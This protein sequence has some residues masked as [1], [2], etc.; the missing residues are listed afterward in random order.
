MISNRS[1]SFQEVQA[2]LQSQLSKTQRRQQIDNAI[3]SRSFEPNL[4]NIKELL[5]SSKPYQS[6]NDLMSI[7]DNDTLLKNYLNK[8]HNL[9]HYL[10]YKETLELSTEAR[11]TAPEPRKYGFISKV[12]HPDSYYCAVM[13]GYLTSVLHHPQRKDALD[14]LKSR[15]GLRPVVQQIKNDA[16]EDAWEMLHRFYLNMLKNTLARPDDELTQQ[17]KGLVGDA[18]RLRAITDSQP[19]ADHSSID[20]IEVL[21]PGIR[22]REYE[23]RNGKLIP[24]LPETAEEDNFVNV[25]LLSTATEEE[26][27]YDVIY[28]EGSAVYKYMQPYLEE[29]KQFIYGT[30][31]ASP[32]V[33]TEEIKIEEIS[34][35]NLDTPKPDEGKWQP[36][37]DKCRL[38][39]KT[40]NEKGLVSASMT[41]FKISPTQYYCHR[42]IKLY[43]SKDDF[44]YSDESVWGLL[45]KALEPGESLRDIFPKK[46]RK[47]EPDSLKR[48][49]CEAFDEPHFKNIEQRMKPVTRSI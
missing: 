10:S 48:L 31:S 32:T 2:A 34:A 23:L 33:Q 13:M 4:A 35:P 18:M 19:G 7:L 20:A 30:K 6:D 27:H 12:E 39:A 40:V 24:N 5:K 37:F 42:L 36:F 44:T 41:L 8:L 22:I 43:S 17:L 9:R 25:Y 46:T 11:V 28:P 14:L 47:N 21:L 29:Y 49:L 38:L 3:L 45:N 26:Y 16:H 15:I 1:A